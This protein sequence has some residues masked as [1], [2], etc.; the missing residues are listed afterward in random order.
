MISYIDWRM[1]Y[2]AFTGMLKRA[3][4][5]SVNLKQNKKLIKNEKR[6]KN[7]YTCN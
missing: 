6:N 4:K 2:R 5:M 7:N 1:M 3:I